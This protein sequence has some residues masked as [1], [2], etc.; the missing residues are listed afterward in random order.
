[1]GQRC[2]CCGWSLVTTFTPPILE[3]ERD[4]TISLLPGNESN[5]GALR[6][7]SQVLGCNYVAA[8]KMLLEGTRELF[9]GRTLE[10]LEKWVELEHAGVAVEITPE[11]PYDR[12]CQIAHCDSAAYSNRIKS[13]Q[14]KN[15]RALAGRPILSDR[16]AW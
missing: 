1:M 12:Y 13:A 4:Y 16:R 7:V 9:T 3:D 11:F 6:A 2:P 10:V 14:E 15:L 5:L 8:K